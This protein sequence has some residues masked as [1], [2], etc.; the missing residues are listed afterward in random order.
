[1]R[2]ANSPDSYSKHHDLYGSLEKI[3][4]HDKLKGE[5]IRTVKSVGDGL[6]QSVNSNILL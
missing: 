3:R 2:I 1:M 4:G 5:K 6:N